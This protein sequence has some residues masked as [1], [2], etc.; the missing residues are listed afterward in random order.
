MTNGTIM[1]NKNSTPT[2]DLIHLVRS[3]IIGEKCALDGPFGPRPIV[4]GDYTASGRALSFIEDYIRNNV[5]PFYA[6]THTEASATGRITGGLR[7]QARSIIK[8]SVGAGEDDALIFCGSGMTG[9]VNHLI[10]ILGL[11][12]PKDLDRKH[13]FSSQISEIDRPV[14]FIGPFE[15]HSN[16]LPWRETIADVVTIGEDD[17]G[18]IDIEELR[19]ALKKYKNRK[20][21]IGSFSAASNVTGIL[22]DTDTITE[23]LHQHSA[24]AFWDYAAAAPYVEL[25]MNPGND[26]NDG[27]G[28]KSLEKDAM[29]ISPH[30]FVGGPGTPGILIIKKHLLNNS[31]PVQ[32]GGGTVAYVSSHQHHYLD[33]PEVREEGG[34]PDIIGSIRAGLAFQLKDRIGADTIKNADEKFLQQALKSWQK[35]PRINVLGNLEVPRLAIISFIIKHRGKVLHHEFIVA[36]LNDLFGIQA[37]GGCSCAGPYGHR[38]LKI[39]RQ[40]SS[41]FEKLV[42]KGVNG[43][44]PGWTRIGFNYFFSQE[45]V[46]YI[47][48]AINMIADEGWKLL[49][50]YSFN[51]NTGLWRHNAASDFPEPALDCFPVASPPGLS[52]SDKNG[53]QDLPF[54]ELLNAAKQQFDGVSKMPSF[55][56]PSKIELAAQCENLR[57]FTTPQESLSRLQAEADLDLG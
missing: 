13:G 20:L 26:E 47:I 37:R 34:T 40:H 54:N 21:K 35:N 27:V 42:I 57:W 36:L 28:S 2:Q 1:A 25:E 29:I 32:P 50:H 16:E 51:E 18:H 7:E 46:D 31:V 39:D 48:A 53:K 49:P 43:M 33:D 12:I 24:L 15:H 22:S 56:T 52:A 3:S 9:A 44:K 4:Y 5:L 30:K 14:V 23:L 8:A 45:T 38:L 55:A 41:D 10:G 19:I 6:N 11:N 17:N